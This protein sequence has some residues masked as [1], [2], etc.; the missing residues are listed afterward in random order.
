[1][2]SLNLSTNYA[3]GQYP[4]INPWDYIYRA[5][6]A[7]RFINRRAKF[8]A[9]MKAAFAKWDAEEIG[10]PGNSPSDQGEDRGPQRRASEVPLVEKEGG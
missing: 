2:K 7:R 10:E 9:E 3:L 1:V 6:G 8:R 5:R 4:F